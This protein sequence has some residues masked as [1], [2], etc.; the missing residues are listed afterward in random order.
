[1]YNQ[2]LISWLLDGPPWV[3]YRTRKDLLGETIN[4]PHLVAARLAMINH[5][6]IIGLVDELIEWPGYPLKRHNDANHLIHKLTFLADLGFAREDPGI[7][8][9]ITKILKHQSSDGPFYIRMSI[10]PRYGGNGEIQPVWMLCDAPLVLYSLIK[11]G[12]VDHPQV[13]LA[14]EFLIKLIR[15]NG[16]PCVTA[17]ELGGFKGPGRRN[18][19]CPY[20]TLVMLK[21]MTLVPEW[22]DRIASHIGVETILDL[23]S[24]RREIRPYLFAMGTHFSRLKAPLIWYDILHVLDVLSQFPWILNN[25]RFEEMINVL[26]DKADK[27]GRFTAESIW[28]AW[29][30]WEFGQKKEPS[31]WITLLAQRIISRKF[32]GIS[33]RQ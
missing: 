3:T 2:N 18:D 20:A 24:H 10:H 33:E 7:E 28:M 16:W 12:M 5:P 4:T 21:V 1:M 13:Q 22:R 15:E 27:L 25:P 23:W 11:F 32:K 29:K 8:N 26:V 9:I 14:G 31:R 30:D 19:P 17:T 6:K